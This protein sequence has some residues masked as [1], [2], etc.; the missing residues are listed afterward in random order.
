MRIRRNSCNNLK[1]AADIP[2]SVPA[3]TTEC[4]QASLEKFPKKIYIFHEIQDRIP[5]EDRIEYRIKEM[6][7][8]EV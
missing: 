5:G 3:S 4:I 1:I 6:S 2:G 8:L 7:S